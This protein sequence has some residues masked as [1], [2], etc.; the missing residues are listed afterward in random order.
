MAQSFSLAQNFLK[1]HLSRDITIDASLMGMGR[2]PGNLSIELIA[3]YMNEYSEKNYD[4][5]YM[6]DAIQDYIEPIKAKEPW[7]YT[8][9][10]FLSAKYNLHRNYAEYFLNKGD[11]TNRD[12]NYILARITKEK[13]TVF[14]AEYADSLYIE[15]QNN[16]IDDTSDR[17]KL[18]EVLI[19]KDVLVLAPGSSILKEKGKINKYIQEKNPVVISLNFI[20]QE[21]DAHIAFFSN[22]KRI[23]K[24]GEY[25][26]E[27]ITTSNLDVKETTYKIDFNSIS[28]AFKQGCNSLILLLKL[29]KQLNLPKV[30]V[31]GADGYQLDSENYFD[32]RYV[33]AVEHDRLFNEEVGNALKELNMG[34]DFITSSEYQK[35]F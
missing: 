25:D 11:L 34:I 6:M 32:S 23:D 28:G 2:V 10:Y 20:S 27:I 18:E 21:Y 22:N 7:G 29:L 15:Y 26:C 3:E 35:Y 12:I 9:T 5:N 24:I 14:D 30:T 1:K 13:T 19:G 8:P 31:A 4:I 16:Q 17:K 33:G